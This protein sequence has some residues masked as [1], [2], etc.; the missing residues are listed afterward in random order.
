MSDTDA[1]DNATEN[2]DWVKPGTWDLYATDVPVTT[3]RQLLF[4][5]H[6]TGAPVDIQKDELR[7][8][9]TLPAWGPA[10]KALKLQVQAFLAS[11]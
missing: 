3:L 10:P 8:F 7:H 11:P 1:A 6:L 2:E 9:T 5:L 4:V